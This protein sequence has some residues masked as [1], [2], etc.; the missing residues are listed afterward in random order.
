MVFGRSRL[1]A[2]VN[3]P[4]KPEAEC[5][6]VIKNICKDVP[7][8][9]EVVKEVEICVNTPKEVCINIDQLKNFPFDIF[10]LVRQAHSWQV[11]PLVKRSSISYLTGKFQSDC[12]Q[13]IIAFKRK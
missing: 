1:G 7:K 4:S 13:V 11:K 12:H 2:Y 3:L 10:R 9:E 6:K 8:K 5:A